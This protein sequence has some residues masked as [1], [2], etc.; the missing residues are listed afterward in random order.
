MMLEAL[1]ALAEREGLLE[2]TSYGKRLAHVQVRI[3]DEG[4]V[5]GVV[6]L[7]DQ[8]KG[9]VM[10]LPSAPKRTVGIAPAFLVDNAQYALGIPKR[11]KGAVADQRATE[12]A[13]EC[14]SAFAATLEEASKASEDVGLRA[15]AAFQRKLEG[16]RDR[17]I[18]MSPG[19]EWTGDET[20]VFVR[21]ADGEMYIHAR[22][23]VRA[24]WAS[25]RSEPS[26]ARSQRCLV[27]GAMAPAARLHDVIKRIPEAQKAG[28]SL[29]S[30]NAPAFTSH[31][32]A[33]GANAPVSQ[34][35]A[36][37]Y[38][39]ALNWLL[40][41]DG[42]RRFRS[43]LLVGGDSVMLFWTRDRH[44]ISDILLECGFRVT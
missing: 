22:P 15:V 34:R 11:K 32:F 3:D 16:E 30:F 27:T 36:D 39:R 20:I 7:G 26:T 37:G 10:S 4:T 18:A 40:E 12:R 1:V 29:V 43:G 35:A 44:A 42:E 21:D 28:A 25:K 38:V 5:L 19:R 24:Y 23:A 2:D 13:R 9:Q 6:P 14:A 41:R 8:G 31:G 17:I 33:Q